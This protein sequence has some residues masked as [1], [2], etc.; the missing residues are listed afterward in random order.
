[1]VKIQV[2]IMH[3]DLLAART[4]YFVIKFLRVIISLTSILSVTVLLVNNVAQ[5]EHVALDFLTAV[6]TDY[7]GADTVACA[8]N[9]AT[10]S[11]IF[12]PYDFR[13]RTPEET[14]Y[15]FQVRRDNSNGQHVIYLS[16]NSS[17]A[18]ILNQGLVNG[19]WRCELR[20]GNGG[21]WNIY[22]GLYYRNGKLHASRY[23]YRPLCRQF[24][25]H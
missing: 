2:Q 16:R 25:P 3:V 24:K 12:Y 15:F 8:S 11:D 4:I 14:D 23:N 1:M 7:Q 10:E 6:T 13:T 20:D 19:I 5:P 18:L 17:N 22:F 9:N 21:I